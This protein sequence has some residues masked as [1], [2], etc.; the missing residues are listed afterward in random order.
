MNEQPQA[1]DE[2]I[3]GILQG[4]DGVASQVVLSD[5]RKLIVV[6]IAW[7]YDLGE[8]FAHVT[9]NVSP[10]VDGAAVDVFSTMLVEAIVDP[11]DGAVL[12]LAA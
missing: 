9:T 10:G 1:R 2:E 5:G 12:Y 6:N 3:L 4:R 7:G 11:G 8:Q